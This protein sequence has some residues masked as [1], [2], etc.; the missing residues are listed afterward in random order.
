MS[1]SIIINTFY[2]SADKLVE[3]FLEKKADIEQ[4]KRI[5]IILENAHRYDF[6]HWMYSSVEYIRHGG[7]KVQEYKVDSNSFDPSRSIF[8]DGIIR[9]INNQTI[10]DIYLANKF[11]ETNQFFNWIQR[12]NMAV[13]TTVMEARQIYRDYTT[14]LLGIVMSHNPV[15]PEEGSFGRLSAHR[16]QLALRYLLVETFNVKITDIVG[17][18]NNIQKKDPSATSDS[19]IVDDK[20]RD[21][22]LS[23]YYQF[24]DQV[25]DFLLNNE[26]YPYCIML[27]G[28]KAILTTDW[29]SKNVIT[30]SMKSSRLHIYRYFHFDQCRLLS[31]EEIA[32]QL[33][34]EKD[35]LNHTANYRSSTLRNTIKTS[36]RLSKNFKT[37][38]KDYINYSDRLS[39]GL[40][41]MKAYFMILLDITGMNDSTL[42]TMKWDDDEFIDEVSQ[43]SFR[44]IKRRA[45]NKEVVFEIQST[46]MSSFRKFIRLRRFVLNGQ[47]CE[48]LF[49]VHYGKEAK[50]S[51]DQI[52]G[53][54]GKECY[55]AHKTLWSELSHTGSQTNRKSKNRWLIRQTNGNIYLSSAIMQHSPKTNHVDYPSETNEE[56]QEQMGMYLMFMQEKVK[57]KSGKSE[58][59]SVGECEAHEHPAIID[60]FDSPI[61]PDCTN[62]M[63]CLFCKFYR[64]FPNEENIWKLISLEYV[65]NEIT[66]L[67]ARSQVHFD[68]VMGPILDRIEVL[69]RV[70]VEKDAETICIIEKLRFNVYE[71]QNLHWYW[72]KRLELLWRRGVV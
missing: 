31:K 41:A 37:A 43:Q 16:K 51:K 54:Y 40:R 72:E 26:N 3:S 67:N 4:Y 12:C 52:R 60:S 55:A 53:A 35:W 42:A 9:Y 49:F 46:F 22:A 38:N 2:I 20:A 32:G 61:K 24:F 64:I 44:N 70:I 71:K 47:E 7:P 14:Y 17:F 39:L 15:A 33:S 30:Q 56:K 29:G 13:P 62:T 6:S 34:H 57:N 50:I 68:S 23:Y 19:L 28:N 27:M 25:S 36:Q 58:E 48:Y 59:T 66:I 21:D 45:G 65:I 8:I 18:T 10:G 1:E 63:T 11:I 69:L 5:G